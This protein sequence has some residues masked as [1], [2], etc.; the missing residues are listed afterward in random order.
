MIRPILG[1][2]AG[3][4]V[5]I[6]IVLVCFLTGPFVFGTDLMLEEGSYKA[7]FFWNVCSAII[8]IVASVAGGAVCQVIARNKRA[9]IA[10]AILAFVG[11]IPA[12]VRG[13]D[14]EPPARPA[15]VVGREAMIRSM[16]HRY[17][18]MITRILNVII[19][20]GGVLLGSFL[21][22]REENRAA[23]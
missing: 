11:G 9:A 21:I 17:E 20:T 7:S 1:F 8:G 23:E 10:L 5:M 18:P 2:V 14:P 13:P 3:L 12:I 22:R 19:G 15:D 6:V 16:S 4:V